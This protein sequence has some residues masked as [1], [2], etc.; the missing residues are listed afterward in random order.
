MDNWN[1]R[2]KH[3]RDTRGATSADL[4]RAAGIS[5]ASVSNWFSGR[6]KNIRP[7]N[8]FRVCDYLHVSARWVA[9]GAGTMEIASKDAGVDAELWLDCEIALNAHLATLDGAALS[10]RQRVW[11][12]ATLYE[13][14]ATAGAESIDPSSLAFAVAVLVRESPSVRSA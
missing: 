14:A 12:V 9:T 13:Q 6:T 7:D 11:L 1:E 4:E 2:L 5:S 10:L 8:L 3:A